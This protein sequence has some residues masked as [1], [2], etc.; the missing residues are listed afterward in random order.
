MKDRVGKLAYGVPRTLDERLP[1]WLSLRCCPGCIPLP[2]GENFPFSVSLLPLLNCTPNLSTNCRYISAELGRENSCHSALRPRLTFTNTPSGLPTPFYFQIPKLL[3]G[4]VDPWKCTSIGVSFRGKSLDGGRLLKEIRASTRYSKRKYEFLTSLTRDINWLGGT[5][6]LSRRYRELD[7]HA[8]LCQP[9][10]HKA[11]VQLKAVQSQRLISESKFITRME[12]NGIGVLFANGTDIDPN[13]IKPKLHICRS[14]KEHDLFHYCRLLQSF[15]TANLIGRQLR[16]LVF[17]E[18]QGRPFVMGAIGLSSSPYSLSSRDKFLQW[19][20]KGRMRLLNRGLGSLMQLAVC[21]SLPPYS[22][23]LC[24][25]LMAALALSEPIADAYRLR[26]KSKS[27]AGAKLLGLITICA[28]GLHCPI[29]HRIMLRP[30]GLYQRI[31]ETAGYTTAFF[32]KNTMEKARHLVKFTH[33][34]ID[35]QVFGKSLRIIKCALRICDLPY[36]ALVKVGLPKGIYMGFASAKALETLRKGVTSARVPA[37][38][39]SRVVQYWQKHLLLKRISRNDV[40]VKFRRF[41][42]HTL[43]LGSQEPR[44]NNENVSPVCRH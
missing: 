40:N 20:V 25:K 17:D 22:Y 13:R 42:S 14:R 11:T 3:P 15:P 4:G 2:A 18:G 30:G 37:L 21:M 16:A 32:S 39:E 36:A 27:R 35:A 12:K 19:N 7:F 41:E 10:E 43:L 34:D 26:Y 33:Q 31:G 8:A 44:R 5:A 29:F 6:Q 9:T 28:G 23:L 24:G 1:W 38:P